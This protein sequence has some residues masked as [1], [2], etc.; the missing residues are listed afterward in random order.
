[1]IKGRSVYLDLLVRYVVK[2]L[3]ENFGLSSA[4]L[5]YV[6][7]GSAEVL[8][9]WG[10]E[11]ALRAIRQKVS[12]ILLDFHQGEL[13]CVME[14]IPLTLGDLFQFIQARSRLE[15]HLE[16]RKRK[17]FSELGEETFFHRFFLPQGNLS[18]GERFVPIA[19][20]RKILLRISAQLVNFLRSSPIS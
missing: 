11:E 5:L 2:H 6:G 1:M 20:G 19:G 13:Y 3:S 7:G 14:W 18:G 12:N 9:P 15:E 8:L 16:I 10:K 17:R 4:C